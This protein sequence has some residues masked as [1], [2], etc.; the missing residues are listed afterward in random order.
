MKNPTFIGVSLSDVK[1]IMVIMHIF[2]EELLSQAVM[3]R[4][5]VLECLLSGAHGRLRLCLVLRDIK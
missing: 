1:V 3:R 4:I 2:M 5:P